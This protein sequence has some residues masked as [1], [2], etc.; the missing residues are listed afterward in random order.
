MVCEELAKAAS[1]DKAEKLG[2][3]TTAVVVTLG[4]S[5]ASFP[6]WTQVYIVSV[7]YESPTLVAPAAILQQ[8]VGKGLLNLSITGWTMGAEYRRTT[9][10]LTEW[11]SSLDVS[12][13]NAHRSNGF[14]ADGEPAPDSSFE[15][16]S[17]HFKSGF[18]RRHALRWTGDYRLTCL[19][20]SVSGLPP[21]ES[22]FWERPYAGLQ[23]GQ[24]W[25]QITSFDPLMNR[26][27][28][29]KATGQYQVYA[30]DSIWWRGSAA[31]GVGKR[32]GPMFLRTDAAIFLGDG[33]NKVSRFLVGGGWELPGVNTLYGYR[34][35]EF[36]IDR[37]LLTTACADWKFSKQ[38]EIGYRVGS[39]M[40]IDLEDAQL[41]SYGEA[42]RVGWQWQGWVIA[43]GWGV[44]GNPLEARNLG[45]SLVSA[46]LT[47]ALW[48]PLVHER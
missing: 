40:A 8:P 41:A 26:W 43:L 7:L 37:G 13:L 3:T 20:E 47:A 28:G 5:L 19:Y 4:L 17:F 48:N 14:Y 34:Y 18:K 38:W 29:L 27:D 24:A 31:L 15:N 2:R 16:A 6:A 33:L 30:G 25:E 10:S 36:R 21:E 32:L 45:K 12:P 44:R 1:K 39:L 46:S 11:T 23:I 9:N 42:I 35:G 22:A